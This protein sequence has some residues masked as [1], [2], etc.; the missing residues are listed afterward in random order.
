M[1]PDAEL[2]LVEVLA[3]CR[4]EKD[5]EFVL[6]RLSRFYAQQS[7]ENQARLNTVFAGWMDSGDPIKADHAVALVARLGIKSLLPK[8]VSSLR[9][10]RSGKS[11]LPQYF[12]QLLVPAID[13]L[14]C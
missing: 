7:A 3:A 12:E 6:D 5:G 9:D 11:N 8:L 4:N 13:K 1:E 2:A 10:V 14:Q